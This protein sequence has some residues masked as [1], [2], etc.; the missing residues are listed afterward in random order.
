[1]TLTYPIQ[2]LIESRLC[3]VVGGGEVAARKAEALVCA[4]A[5][6]KVVAPEAGSEMQALI[7]RESIEW[8]QKTFSPNDI[9]GAFVVVAATDDEKVNQM[10]F[11]CAE[12]KRI[13]VNVVDR[14]NLCSFFVPSVVRRGQLTLT[15]ATGGAGPAVSMKLRKELEAQFG[16]EYAEYLQIIAECRILAKE[17]YPSDS[18]ARMEAGRRVADLDLLSLIREGRLLEAKEE[19]RACV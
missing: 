19:A 8:L 17:K 9:D 18:E 14:P 2:L 5:Q 6:A 15:V 1:M 10:V 3:V 7:Q 4:G 11:A 16:D 13:L 12:R